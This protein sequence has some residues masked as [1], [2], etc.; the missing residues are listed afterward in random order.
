[1]AKWTEIKKQWSAA[2]DEYSEEID[3]LEDIE[4]ISSL[5]ADF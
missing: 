4:D 1:M 3:T 2:N 5:L